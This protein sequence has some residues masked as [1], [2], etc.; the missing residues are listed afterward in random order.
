[1]FLLFSYNFLLPIGES[2]TCCLLKEADIAAGALVVTGLRRQ[3]IDFTEPFLSLR[4][5]ALVR[6]PLATVP[7]PSQ[8][9][10]RRRR[11]T[12]TTCSPPRRRRP[13]PARIR[14]AM[15]LLA[16]ELSYGVVRGS[17]VERAMS[18]SADPLTRALW[19]RVAK[20]WPPALVDSVQEGIERARRESYAF[21]VDSPMAAYV[22]GRRPCDLYVTEP[23]LQ[24]MTYAF[25]VRRG[26]RRLRA[27]L[28]RE[29]RRARSSGE[30][31]AMYLRWWRDE[32]TDHDD[33]HDGGSFVSETHIPTITRDFVGE[34]G[35]RHVAG[36]SR[37]NDR[38]SCPSTSSW[39]LSLTA[40]V[41]T[42]WI[43]SFH[44]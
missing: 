22:A 27:A 37:L 28:D 6:K 2:N 3:F 9:R 21:I 34:F 12:T 39:R 31:Q 15:D 36:S 14:T 40:A 5:S 26:A 24:Q 11:S 29:L 41:F 10:R 23:F 43:L 42:L 19:S 38:S 30:M 16:S 25:A 8:D 20:F 1:M 17:V 44:L 18:T 7:S 13:G 4:S 35:R 32:C 33:H